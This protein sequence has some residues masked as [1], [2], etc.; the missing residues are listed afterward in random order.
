MTLN[1]QNNAIIWFLQSKSHE[2]EVLHTF[3]AALFV[4]FEINLST[5]KIILNKQ[6]NFKN[7][8]FSPNYMKMKYYTCC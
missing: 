4:N 1:Q 8:L 6:N 7:G 2:K 3:L 5:L